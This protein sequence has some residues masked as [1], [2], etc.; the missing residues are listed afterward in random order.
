MALIGIAAP[1][2]SIISAIMSAP[3]KTMIKDTA[4]IPSIRRIESL[5]TLFASA[6]RSRVT[7]SDTMRDTAIGIPDVA[8][9]T[10]KNINIVCR[11]VKRHCLGRDHTHKRNPEYESQYFC[12]YTRR[13]QNSSAFYK[14]LCHLLSPDDFLLIVI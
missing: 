10:K 5:N 4:P 14:G 2:F 13:A 1:G 9:V 11:I 6:Y 7:R 8:S 3:P 12:D